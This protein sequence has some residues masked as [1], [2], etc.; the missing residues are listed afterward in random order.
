[1]KDLE[2]DEKQLILMA[3]AIDEIIKSLIHV[4]KTITNTKEDL[5]KRYMAF[6]SIYGFIQ[7]YESIETFNKIAFKGG[8]DLNNKIFHTKKFKEYGWEQGK[9]DIVHNPFFVNDEEEHSELH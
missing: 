5:F 2:I 8:Y 7:L 9:K 3:E 6:M 1:M 4:K